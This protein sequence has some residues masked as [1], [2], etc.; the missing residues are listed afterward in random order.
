MNTKVKAKTLIDEVNTKAGKKILND[1][2]VSVESR[3]RHRKRCSSFRR[4]N[5]C[6]ELE[7]VYNSIQISR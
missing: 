2:Q 4:A 6:K 3:I 5:D 1:S 7:A